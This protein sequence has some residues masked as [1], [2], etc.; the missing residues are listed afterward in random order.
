MIFGSDHPHNHVI[1]SISG[2]DK[3]R[4]ATATGPGHTPT[5]G[6]VDVRRIGRSYAERREDGVAVVVGAERDIGAMFGPI[7][8]SCLENSAAGNLRYSYG[9]TDP[10]KVVSIKQIRV[11]VL[12]Q[13]N[14]KMQGV[15]SGTST[16]NGPEL[17]RSPSI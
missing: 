6:D 3:R 12:S 1:G 17:P 5:A 4:G 14:H 11:A 9:R 7:G 13:C 16:S 15:A 8:D 2:G 10:T